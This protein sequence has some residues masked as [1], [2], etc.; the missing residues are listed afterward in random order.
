[1]RE[2]QCNCSGDDD[3][4]HEK[5]MQDRD[6]REPLPRPPAK[7]DIH[8]NPARSHRHL[9]Q[10]TRPNNRRPQRPHRQN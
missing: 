6:D 8:T 10:T 5:E 3:R 1:M 4:A 7:L 9:W 2:P